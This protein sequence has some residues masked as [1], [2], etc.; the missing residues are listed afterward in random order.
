MKKIKIILTF[1]IFFLIISINLDCKAD[2][3]NWTNFEN[4]ILTF[5]DRGEAE[6]LQYDLK[7]ENVT[8][9]TNETTKYYVFITNNSNLLDVEKTESVL[10]N[11]AIE[12]WTSSSEKIVPYNKI[13]KFIDT[14][15][16]TYVWIIEGK[17]N[18]GSNY[19]YNEVLHAKKIE[20]PELSSVGKRIKTHFF[21]H[22][23]EL[24]TIINICEPY[25][26]SVE[27]NA[28]IKLG[29]VTDYNAL[30]SAK[31]KNY[32]KLLNYAKKTQPLT[33]K[34]ENLK[35]KTNILADITMEIGS[36][37]YVYVSLDDENNKYR[38]IEDVSLYQYIDYPKDD[39]YYA[40]DYRALVLPE[41]ENFSWNEMD[42]FKPVEPEDPI[43]PEEA[44]DPTN[45]EDTEDPEEQTKPSDSTDEST[46]PT[47]P[48]KPIDSSKPT[49]PEKDTG[50]E[51]DTTIKE[52]LPKTGEKI[53]IK[54]L[55]ILILVCAIYYGIK[56]NKMKDIK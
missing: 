31:N 53:I 14:N 28:T 10:Q 11:N 9:D 26:N 44:I 21:Y 2:T 43:D 17:S 7:F 54:S 18:D 25:D 1:V 46:D 42:L 40:S 29:K 8:F 41:N 6:E 19:E 27:R 23:G 5:V 45:P 51:D 55:I 56:L 13:N 39:T 33:E 34:T 36:Y 24:S 30:L 3:Q 52:E 50:K 12:V 4:V 20:K 22:Y 38:S 35:S 37:Y 47:N 48:E 32:N 15:E 49:Y 16:D